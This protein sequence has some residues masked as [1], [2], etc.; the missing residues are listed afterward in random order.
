[1]TKFVI[2]TGVATLISL[3]IQVSGLLPA[4]KKYL[5][6]TTIFLLGA[7]TGLLLNI[8][9]SLQLTI[10]EAI[11]MRQIFGSLLY[12]GTG[13]LAFI[14]IIMSVMIEDK[15]RREMA[16][17]AASGVC[18]FLVLLLIFMGTSIFN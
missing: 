2:I 3:I 18:G 10:P 8:S 14:L 17:K 13:L 7:T 1:M 12:G 5:T 15:D 9:T 16:A 4:Y 6:H 11:T